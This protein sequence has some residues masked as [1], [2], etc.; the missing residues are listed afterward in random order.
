MSKLDLTA[1]SLFLASALSLGILLLAFLVALVV[2]QRRRITLERVHAQRI[3]AAQEQERSRVARELH[4]DALQRV[5]VIRHEL[6]EVGRHVGPEA[7]HHLHGLA[8]EVQDLAAVLR[9]AAHQLHPSVVEKAGLVRALGDL[10]GEFGR[11]AGLEVT[12]VLPAGDV[13][14]DPD[15]GVALYRIAQEALRNVARHAGVSHADLVLELRD[16]SLN[17]RVADAGK[18]FAQGTA[19]RDQGLG[20]IAMRQ[21]AEILGGRVTVTAQPGGGTLVVATIPTSGIP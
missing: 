17:L 8:G 10:A 12:A 15:V 18:G 6:D 1:W 9:T 3:L 19:R 13:V 4:D 2:S 7:V 16:G 5:A 14:V 20:F 11:T 21:R